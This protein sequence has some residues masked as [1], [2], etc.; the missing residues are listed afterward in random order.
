MK[1]KDC[2]K[3]L[4]TET[5]EYGFCSLPESYFPTKFD[6]DCCYL[7][8]YAIKCKDC[9]R[10][11]K[12]FACLT[13]DEND[14]VSDCPGFIDAEE[15]NVLKAFLVWLGRGNYSR[16]KVLKL[17]DEFEQS[18]EYNFFKNIVNK[19]GSSSGE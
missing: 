15:E 7:Q 18:E 17:C 3:Y 5:N 2:K 1:C 6:D 8:N 12:D 14:D 4:G 11:G 19:E 9:Y 16:E 10:F 13:A